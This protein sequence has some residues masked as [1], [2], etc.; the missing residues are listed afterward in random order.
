[1]VLVS[2]D[3]EGWTLQRQQHHVGKSATAR[4]GE[5]QLH[6]QSARPAH[7][8]AWPT[9]LTVPAP[10]C[11]PWAELDTVLSWTQT[12]SLA[13]CVLQICRAKGSGGH[14]VVGTWWQLR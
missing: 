1:M 11:E 8:E 12:C 2:P 10:L 13:P 14:M 5:N 7:K 9:V 4:C 3:A 6:M